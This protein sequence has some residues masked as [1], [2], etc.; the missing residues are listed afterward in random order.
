M[1]HNG[2]EYGLMQAF[3]EG[4]D[5]LQSASRLGYQLPVPDIAEVWRH[6]SVISA[7]LLDLAA[8]A[9][10]WSPD[11]AGFQ[12]RVA[13]SGEGRWSVEAAVQAGVPCPVLTVAL[14]ARF[15]SQVDHTFGEKLLSAMRLG[16]GGHVETPQLVTR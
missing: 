2:I 6:G 9:L 7:W 16:F 5:L 11:L 3:A 13:D 15:R 14:Y 1:V 8:A 12:G 4:F 10:S